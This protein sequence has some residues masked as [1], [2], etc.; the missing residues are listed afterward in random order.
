M[1]VARSLTLLPFKEIFL[2]Q[3]L[4]SRELEDF[5]SVLSHELRAPLTSIL[6]SLRLIEE[7]DNPQSAE[8]R[9]FLDIAIS[10]T[11]RLS[12]LVNDLLELSKIESGQN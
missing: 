1:L 11:E 6:G 4:H 7:F 5:H 3:R 10:S 8:G 12:A 2:K 9:E